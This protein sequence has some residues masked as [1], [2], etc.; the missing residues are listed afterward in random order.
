MPL[1]LFVLLLWLHLIKTGDPLQTAATEKLLQ[2]IFIQK[3]LHCSKSFERGDCH[4][5]G[6]SPCYSLGLKGPLKGSC[7]IKGL[8]FRQW[9]LREVCYVTEGRHGG[10]VGG[11]SPSSYV[12]CEFQAFLEVAVAFIYVLQNFSRYQFGMLWTKVTP[13]KE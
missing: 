1:N 4:I 6:L 7:L 10:H 13:F 8:V 9:S 5:L 11:P 12:I 2:K 3:Q